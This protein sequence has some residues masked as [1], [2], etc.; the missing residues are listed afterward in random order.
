VDRIRDNAFTYKTLVS[1][2]LHRVIFHGL[3]HLCGFKDKY[4]SEQAK[5]RKKE[6]YYLNK[7]FVPRGTS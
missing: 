2:E 4:A 7:Y 6:D 5:M 3:L 1:H